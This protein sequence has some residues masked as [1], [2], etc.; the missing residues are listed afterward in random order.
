MINAT[1]DLVFNCLV[2]NGK[3]DQKALMESRQSSYDILLEDRPQGGQQ[4]VGRNIKMVYHLPNGDYWQLSNHSLSGYSQERQLKQTIGVD[5]SV[6]IREG[7]KELHQLEI[8]KRQLVAELDTVKKDRLQHKI[9]WNRMRQVV[10]NA[11]RDMQKLTGE[12]ERI[13]EEAEEAEN[14]VDDTTE[15]EDD[16]K[17]AQESYDMIKSNED[18]MKK[19]LEDLLPGIE[20][21]QNQLEEEAARNEKVM[22][23][24]GV[25]DDKLGQYLNSQEEMKRNI[26]R[27]RDKLERALVVRN[28]QAARVEAGQQKVDETLLRARKIAYQNKKSMESREKSN[29][30]GDAHALEDEEN[31]IQEMES[32]MPVKTRKSSDY[33]KDRINRVNNEIKRERERRNMTETNPEVALEKY[34]RAKNDLHKKTFQI[35]KIA[36]NVESLIDDLK[37]RK[38]KWRSFRCKS[39]FFILLECTYDVKY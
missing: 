12:L 2:D 29:S 5:K 3:I 16:V 31:V 27:K 23:E 22:K 13:R 19:A 11:S 38:K 10:D 28:E 21:L 9:N 39:V 37:D 4:I 26:Q 36:A 18:N 17:R 33:Y 25:A 30:D 20:K 24:L 7:E 8:E 14:V 6:A 1:D 15:L 35:E 34:H 32:I